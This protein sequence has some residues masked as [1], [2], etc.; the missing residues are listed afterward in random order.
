M[1]DNVTELLSVEQAAD[2]LNVTVRFIRRLVAERRIAV[3]RIGRHVRL[4]ADDIE[5]FI[6]A[7]RREAIR[8]RR[9]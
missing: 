4:R 5:A 2:R 3:Y 1:H 9:P 8:R 7:A 6:A